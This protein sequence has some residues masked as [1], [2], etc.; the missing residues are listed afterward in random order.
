MGLDD[1]YPPPEAVIA[2]L[3]PAHAYRYLILRVNFLRADASNVTI[4]LIA[5]FIL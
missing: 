4:R 1:A 3:T 5:T 2:A